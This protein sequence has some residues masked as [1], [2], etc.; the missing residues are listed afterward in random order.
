MPVVGTY[1]DESVIMRR[2]F[3]WKRWSVSMVSMLCSSDRTRRFGITYC[4]CLQGRRISEARNSRSMSQAELSL[5]SA[6]TGILLGLHL[7]L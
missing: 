7:T 6:Y 1:H 2:A 5:P 3:N 4:P